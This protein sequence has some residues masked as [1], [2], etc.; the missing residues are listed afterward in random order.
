MSTSWFWMA[1]LVL[2][3]VTVFLIYYLITHRRKPHINI[4]NKPKETS[5]EKKSLEWDIYLDAILFG[6][7]KNPIVKKSQII[8]E[9]SRQ[10][11]VEASGIFVDQ[12]KVPCDGSFQ[13]TLEAKNKG[14]TRIII[15]E[16]KT[17]PD[18]KWY[19]T[20]GTWYNRSQEALREIPVVGKTIEK[21]TPDAYQKVKVIYAL[22]VTEAKELSY[23]I[24]LTRYA[25]DIEL[26][27]FSG[28]LYLN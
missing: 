2:A 25:D 13:V 6:I 23:T 19:S 28:K 4:N 24:K 12:Q 8:L 10:L 15:E 1:L 17:I 16:K 26:L 18:K 22:S 27:G 11:P 3:F 21:L 14:I 5:N 20:L 9:K 7:D